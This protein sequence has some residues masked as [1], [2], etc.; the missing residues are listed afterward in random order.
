[1]ASDQKSL[2]VT[3]NSLWIWKGISYMY[4]FKV[5]S[6]SAFSVCNVNFKS[7]LP[8]QNQQC[9]LGGLS[10]W[11]LWHWKQTH[12]VAA[13]QRFPLTAMLTWP[14]F[15]YRVWH[16]EGGCKMLLSFP[17]CLLTKGFTVYPQ[18][19]SSGD[20]SLLQIKHPHQWVSF[21]VRFASWFN[22]FCVV[23]GSLQ[24]FF[25]PSILIH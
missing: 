18:S 13:A 10:W 14:L 3:E 11:D 4:Y 9:A 8:K 20:V 2:H 6:L 17:F 15:Q 12:S 23:P 1:M 5:I 22:L 19:L 16:A 25:P 21:L 7:K 24:I